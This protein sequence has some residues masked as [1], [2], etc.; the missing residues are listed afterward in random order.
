MGQILLGRTDSCVSPQEKM[1]VTIRFY[2]KRFLRLF[3]ASF[4]W[5]TVMFVAGTVSGDVTIWSSNPDLFHKWVAS[6]FQIRNFENDV[7][8]S[9]LGWYW[10]L[11]LENQFYFILPVLWFS[12]GRKIF[13]YL[14]AASAVA[15]MFWLPGGTGWFW[16]RP[17]GFI[18]GLLVYRVVSN[19]Q[20]D[21]IL[22]AQIPKWNAGVSLTI[23]TCVLLL[24][25]SVPVFLGQKYLPLSMSFVCMV[26][27]IVLSFS[28]LNCE[29]VKIPAL[30]QPAVFWAAEISYSFYLCHIV[31]WSLL[32]DV[33]KRHNI[34][35]GTAI[36]MEVGLLLACICA[37]CS[38]F[39]I[40]RRF[41]RPRDFIATPIQGK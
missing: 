35:M 14:L 33:L 27:A 8:I 19:E 2:R 1:D 7:H 22:R 25:T 20:T 11:S 36:T 4:F 9:H 31:V 39:F 23:V 12:L 30:L 28:S 13:W 38:Y 29:F 18:W 15:M 17:T 26:S 24:S 5:V 16:F 3:P 41:Y 10:S 34:V 32:K 37:A 40:E 21:R 6:I